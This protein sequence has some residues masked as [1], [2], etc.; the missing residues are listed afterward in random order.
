ME[1]KEVWP[2]ASRWVEAL[3]RFARDP[4][5]SALT[6]EGGMAD[7]EDPVPNPVAFLSNPTSATLHN[8]LSALRNARIPTS[9]SSRPKAPIESSV[10]IQPSPRDILT[11]L[12]TPT[13]HMVPPQFPH[14]I[15]APTFTSEIPSHL[16]IPSHPTDDLGM[17]AGAFGQASPYAHAS[18]SPTAAVSV[19]PTT[20]FYPSADGFDNEL[21][22]YVN[23]PQNWVPSGV[24]ESYQ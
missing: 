21:Q 15:P 4:S 5:G 1:C 6:A 13:I 16:Y 8:R 3:Q 11:P 18:G 23:G 22:F 17:V 24:F 10:T 9:I 12:S 20:V 19:T 7:G 2:L 14:P